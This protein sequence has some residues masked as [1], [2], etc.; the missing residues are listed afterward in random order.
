MLIEL[1]QTEGDSFVQVTGSDR[2]DIPRRWRGGDL[3]DPVDRCLQG[4]VLI[5][6]S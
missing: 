3:N 6:S 1:I 4:E 5:L 2:H